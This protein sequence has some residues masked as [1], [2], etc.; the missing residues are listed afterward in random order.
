MK[1]RPETISIELELRIDDRM[2]ELSLEDTG[3][4][5]FNQGSFDIVE[6]MMR[7]E[8]AIMSDEGF[9]MKKAL[10][11]SLTLYTDDEEESKTITIT[12]M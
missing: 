5:A 7:Q 9:D 8:I 6:T 3:Y 10:P 11:F 12:R 1:L 4:L 2:K